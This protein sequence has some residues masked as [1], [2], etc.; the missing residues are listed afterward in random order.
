MDVIL[1]F[2][3]LFD[4]EKM[5]AGIGLGLAAS[6]VIIYRTGSGYFYEIIKSRIYY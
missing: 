5:C 1:G 6:Q 2:Y 3:G 4:L